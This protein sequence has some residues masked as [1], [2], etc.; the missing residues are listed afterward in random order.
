MTK[1]CQESLPA[2]SQEALSYLKE[3]S[4]SAEAH[5]WEALLQFTGTGQ[6]GSRPASELGCHICLLL[7]RP[8]G[9]QPQDIEHPGSFL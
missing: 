9:D 3:R 7:P 5:R 1:E 4:R 6:E 2:A 8:G